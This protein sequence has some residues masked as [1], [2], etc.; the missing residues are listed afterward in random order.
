MSYRSEH[1]QDRWL[2]ENI[3]RGKREGVFVEFGALDGIFTSNS[4]FFEAELGWRGVL[5]EADPVNFAALLQSPRRA[6]KLCAAIA[7]DYGL[8]EFERVPGIIGWGGLAAT[9]EAEHRQRIGG[10]TEKFI[11]ATLP[12]NAVLAHCGIGAIDYLSADIEGGEF[13]ALRAFD[14]ARFPTAIVDVENNFGG[15]AIA[16]LMAARGYEKIAQLGINDIY[17]RG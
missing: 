2:N 17:R 10:E 12:L 7:A 13:E 14:F 11:V 5:I 6:I 4:A 8:A 3:F 16:A 1:E 9:I 15:T